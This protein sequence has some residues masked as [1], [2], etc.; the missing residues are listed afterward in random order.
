[1]KTYTQEFGTYSFYVAGALSL[2]ALISYRR[3]GGRRGVQWCWGGVA[4][5]QLIYAWEVSRMLR[6]ELSRV[7]RGFASSGD[8]PG[9]TAVQAAGAVAVLVVAALGSLGVLLLIRRMGLALGLAV[10]GVLWSLLVFV[11]ESVSTNPI[12]DFLYERI[13][14]S[15][16]VGWLWMFGALLVAGGAVL[17][18]V[19]PATAPAPPKRA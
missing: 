10:A 19:R 9:K 18:V 15:M 16:L 8:T 7:L 1:M 3:R 12:E 6:F 5:V 13:G 2:L 14:F 11:L 4:V 17:S